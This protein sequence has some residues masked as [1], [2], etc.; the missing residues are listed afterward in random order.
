D[1]D[2]VGDVDLRD[3]R[4]EH[5]QVLV[6]LIRLIAACAENKITAFFQ[7]GSVQLIKGSGLDLG[8][9]RRCG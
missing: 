8:S 3:A 1:I 4:L 6:D 2:A 9:Q 5:V 7:S